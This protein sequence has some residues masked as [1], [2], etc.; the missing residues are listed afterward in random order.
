MEA[1]AE[2]PDPGAGAIAAD[3][4]GLV[5][6]LVARVAR[7]S[8]DTWPDAAGVAA[9]AVELA[10]RCPDLSRDNTLAWKAALAE[11]DSAAEGGTDDRSPSLRDAL[12]S[13]ADVPV[14]IAETGADVAELAALTARLGEG[15]F[16][17]D[18][19]SAAL[20]ADACVRV[21]VHLVTVNLATRE[22]DNRMRDV[23]VAEARARRAAA[24][25]V[26]ASG[27]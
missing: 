7:L 3:T 14:S 16:R 13:A 10:E 5:A 20:L 21:A 22:D 23:A 27:A 18:A 4:I 1:L 26:A 9:Q 24:E 8:R 6:V 15:R 19:A 12:A 25:A 17:S 11:L 2:V